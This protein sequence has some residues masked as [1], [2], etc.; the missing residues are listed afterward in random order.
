M[1]WEEYLGVMINVSFGRR[2]QS[3]ISHDLG[4]GVTVLKSRRRLWAKKQSL[5]PDEKYWFLR[6]YRF[7]K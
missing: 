5:L 6:D 7:G 3:M 1:E 2:Y 4:R